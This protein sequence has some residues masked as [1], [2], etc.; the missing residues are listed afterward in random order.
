MQQWVG[1]TNEIINVNSWMVLK[2]NHCYQKMANEKLDV[3]TEPS[4]QNLLYG[5]FAFVQ[6]GLTF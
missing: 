3:A 2:S 6:W 1:L 5:D 4:P